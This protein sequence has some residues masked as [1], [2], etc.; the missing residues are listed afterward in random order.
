MS[1]RLA[2]RLSL[3]RRQSIVGREEERTLFRTALS[4]ARLPFNVLHVSGP[5]GVGKSTLLRE[6]ERIC[7]EATVPV[8]RLD[9]RNVEPDRDAFLHALDAAAGAPAGASAIERFADPPLRRVILVDTYEILEPLDSWLREALLP[10]LSDE[11][12]TV[13]AGRNP[14]APAWRADPGWL[15]LIRALPLRNLSAE[16][17]RAYLA[18]RQVAE[19][20]H[21]AA[22]AFTH[23]HPLALSLVADLLLQ[24]PGTVFRPEDA[25]D[26]IRTLLQHLVREVPTPTHR[27]ALEAAALLKLTTE[28]LL[29]EVLG[30]PDAHEAFEWLRGLSFVDSGPRGLFP[31][32]LV[33]DA[34][35]ADLRWRNS[36]R[37]AELHDRAR[38]YY[39]R[40]LAQTTGEEQ[41]RALSDYVYLH[42]DNPGMKP[43][44]DWGETGASLPDLAS[45]ADGPVLLEMVRR[46]EGEESA[47]LAEYWLRRQPRGMLVFRGAQQEILGFLAIVGLHDATAADRDADPAVGTAVEYLERHAPLRPDELATHFRFWL[48]ADSYQAVSSTQSLIFLRIAQHYL[49][50]PKLAFTFFP[51]ADPEFWAP[52]CGYIDLAPIPAADFRV[53]GRSYRVYGHDWRLRPPIAWLALLAQREMGMPPRDEAAPAREL[54]PALGPEEFAAAVHGALRNFHHPRELRESPLLRSRQVME[55]AGLDATGA[56]RVAALRAILQEAADALRANPREQKYYDALHHAYFHPAPSQESAARL[57]YISFS[58]FRRHLKSG[59][60]QLSETLWAGEP[61]ADG[62]R[63]D[64]E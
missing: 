50:T 37:F 44:L 48:V 19:A 16:E 36:D 18:N 29:A 13:L 53:G 28:P 46:H 7:E 17:G 51:C 49:S 62:P 39:S 35:S 45:D 64:S 23:G 61:G 3:L 24:R 14:P 30:T 47:R 20:D 42:R 4:A 9:S 1:S 40:K 15:P 22:L 59:V 27:M 63:L 41:Q 31:H 54:P 6:Y 56:Q 25:P 21:Q 32:D 43:F 57:L 34:L 11:V 33:R 2:D 12:L 55:R 10:Q 58:T 52:L 8:V 60:Q 38:G 26:V 5:G